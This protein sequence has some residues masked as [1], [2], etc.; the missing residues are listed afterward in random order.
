[1]QH[2]YPFPNRYVS[3]VQRIGLETERFASAPGNM[4][5]LEMA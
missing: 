2:I 4:C 1:M 5:G 3:L